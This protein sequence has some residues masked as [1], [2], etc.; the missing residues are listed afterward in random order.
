MKTAICPINNRTYEAATFEQDEYFELI[1]NSM[2]CP[3][4]S[5]PVFYRGVTQNG[6]EACFGARHTEGCDMATS[7]HD[8]MQEVVNVS[9]VAAQRI[10]VDFNTAGSIDHLLQSLM[11]SDEFRRSTRII[12]VPGHGEITIA[13]FFVNFA[14]VTENHIGSY[15]G[16]WG[17]IPDARVSG[18]TMWLNSGGPDSACANVDQ[19]YFETIYQRLDIQN[20]AKISGSHIL[21]FGELKKGRRDKKFVLIT[22]PNN[23]TVKF[24][25]RRS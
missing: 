9:Q 13:D 14:D 7:E 11:E 19:I 23:F 17:L 18:N 8:D 3:Q 24:P 12:E 2:I 4:C 22:D 10:V 5:Q 6:R 21:V 16:F 20:A 15:H 25:Y 1:K